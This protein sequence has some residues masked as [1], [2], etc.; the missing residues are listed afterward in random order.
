M[1]IIKHRLK[2]EHSCKKMPQDNEDRAE[3]GGGREV[4]GEPAAM[5]GSAGSVPLP[6]GDNN[7]GAAGNNN[8]N[9][10]NRTRNNN[11]NQNPLINVRDRLF[12]AIFI[13]AALAYARTFPRPMRRFLE[14][15][16]LLNV[17]NIMYVMCLF[18]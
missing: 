13:K 15:I 14:F 16:V 10:N 6:V 1:E 8:T 12:H 3:G 18:L 4:A 2:F 11:N 17:R 9:N 7:G 5:G